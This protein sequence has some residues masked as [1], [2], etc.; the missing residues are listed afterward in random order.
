MK[1]KLLLPLFLCFSFLLGIRDGRIAL[2]RS[3]EPDPVRIFPYR[4]EMLPPEDRKALE[5]GIPITD[6]KSLS[7]LLEDYLS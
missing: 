4:A 6:E 5:K 7:S 3:G 1:K 2:W